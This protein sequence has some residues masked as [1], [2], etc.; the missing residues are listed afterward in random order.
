M[1][2]SLKE[3]HQKW[4]TKDNHILL[5]ANNKI[6]ILLQPLQSLSSS[7]ITGLIFCV[8]ISC[9]GVYQVIS[10]PSEEQKQKLEISFAPKEWWMY[11]Q[12]GKQE[13]KFGEMWDLETYQYGL[14]V[15]LLKAGGVLTGCMI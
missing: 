10:K 7:K 3:T 13:T 14:D 9:Q 4:N 15:W 2:A 6:R 11:M 5:D 8:C 1:S 12:A